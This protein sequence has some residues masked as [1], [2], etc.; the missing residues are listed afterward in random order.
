MDLLKELLGL[1]P[2]YGVFLSDLFSARDRAH[3]LHLA[4]S[5]YAEHVALNELYELLVEHADLMAESYQ[6]KYGKIPINVPASSIR[7]GQINAKT[8]VI[9]LTTF[10]E[11]QAAH[12]SDQVI[13]N[14]FQE[15]LSE[16][17]KIKYKIEN[18]S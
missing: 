15:L 9:A 12:I 11:T 1:P 3:E 18:L 10:L 6:G 8:F 5:S 17:Y 2:G 13:V 4:T 14:Q 16:V 7:W